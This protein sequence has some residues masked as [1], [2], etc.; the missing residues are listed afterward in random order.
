MKKNPKATIVLLITVIV[1]LLAAFLVSCYLKKS[2][3]SKNVKA[4][5]LTEQQRE[6]INNQANQLKEA[7]RR[8]Y[9]K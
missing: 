7:L 5:Q 9:Q 6:Q 8:Q 2:L 1:I 3:V 4:V